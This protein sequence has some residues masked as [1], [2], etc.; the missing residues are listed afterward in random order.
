MT[1]PHHP[2][3]TAADTGR[4]AR[5][6]HTKASTRLNSGPRLRSWLPPMAAAT[7]VP[8]RGGPPGHVHAHGESGRGASSGVHWIERLS[9]H[10]EYSLFLSASMTPP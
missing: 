1:N 9:T 2:E 6:H 10:A 8:G 5:V 7:C 3:R 4:R